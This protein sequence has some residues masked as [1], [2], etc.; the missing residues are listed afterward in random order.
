MTTDARLEAQ[1]TRVLRR[2]YD[3]LGRYPVV[4]GI[5]GGFH[6]PYWRMIVPQPEMSLSQLLDPRTIVAPLRTADI[7]VRPI[8]G[9]EPGCWAYL[10][11]RDAPDSETVIF[12]LE[13]L[14][15]PTT[16]QRYDSTRPTG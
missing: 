11:D 3:V 2:L 15:Y 5:P 6:M 8:N 10:M 12:R 4:V 1:L 13:A 16:G 7:E 14:R 9:Y